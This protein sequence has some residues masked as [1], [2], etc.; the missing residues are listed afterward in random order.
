V[1]NEIEE[2]QSRQ[3]S[4]DGIEECLSQRR[5]AEKGWGK[6]CGMHYRSAGWELRS[7]HPGLR[8]ADRRVLECRMG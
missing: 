8:S 3:R 4:T 5:S 7:S 2:S 1:R 6:E